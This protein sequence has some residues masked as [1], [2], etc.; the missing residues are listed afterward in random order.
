MSDVVDYYLL[1]P[2]SH[3]FVFREV[4]STSGELSRELLAVKNW[5]QGTTVEASGHVCGLINQYANLL[6]RRIWARLGG[7]LYFYASL[8][9]FFYTSGVT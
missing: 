7:N 4:Q 8:E 5:G 6:N 3:Y 9:V 2:P 1:L